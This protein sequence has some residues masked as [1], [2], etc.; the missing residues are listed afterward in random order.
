[1]SGV[2][3]IHCTIAVDGAVTDCSVVSENP[4]GRGLGEAALKV[5]RFLKIRPKLVDGQ[6]IE[7]TFS[8]PI[9]FGPQ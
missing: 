6:P 4:R 8:L 5:P 9:R 1:M 7:S 2:A 3:V